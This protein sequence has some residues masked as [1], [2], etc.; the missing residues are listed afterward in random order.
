MGITGHRILNPHL[1]SNLDNITYINIGGADFTKLYTSNTPFRL[2][3][4]P[5]GKYLIFYY[6]RF[7]EPETK[8]LD[9]GIYNGVG[10]IEEARAVLNN[11]STVTSN[12][13]INSTSEI[14]ITCSAFSDGIA[15][16][17]Y[18]RAYA[19]ELI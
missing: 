16:R 9:C 1:N 5:A 3:T 13:Y 4:L 2:G 18:V 7:V 19:I 17:G 15:N 11:S 8:G 12:G 6:A 10:M 14:T